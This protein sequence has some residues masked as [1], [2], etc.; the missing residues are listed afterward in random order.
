MRCRRVGRVL[1]PA[2]TPPYKSVAARQPVPR[3]SARPQCQFEE[4]ASRPH[5]R[6]HPAPNTA[7]PGH[8]AALQ[9]A[10]G[11]QAQRAKLIRVAAA[12]GLAPAIGTDHTGV[13]VADRIGGQLSGAWRQDRHQRRIELRPGVRAIRFLKLPIRKRARAATLAVA[14]RRRGSE[15]KRLRGCAVGVLSPLYAASQLL[16]LLTSSSLGAACTN[17]RAGCEYGQIDP[18]FLPS[19]CSRREEDAEKL[20]S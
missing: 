3:R 15:V 6:R 5:G 9:R 19:L 14:Q 1:R 18:W 17:R 16:S 13:S 7:Q 8:A 4:P 20:R 2:I 10:V 11:Q 12:D